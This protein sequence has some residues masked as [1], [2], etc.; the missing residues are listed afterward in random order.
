MPQ[1]EIFFEQTTGDKHIEVLKVYDRNYA[2]EVF[3]N[4]E[5][6]AQKFLSNALAMGETYDVADVPTVDDPGFRDFLWEEVLE[7]AREDGN[8]LS[9]FVVNETKGKNKQGL[10]VSPDWPSARA[11]ATS[12]VGETTNL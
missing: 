1:Q 4:M 12:R 10:Y 6:E 5:T 8:L 2:H 11:F 7:A 3:S 9:F